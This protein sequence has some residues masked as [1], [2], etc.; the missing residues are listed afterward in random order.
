MVFWGGKLH[1]E[2]LTYPNIMISSSPLSNYYVEESSSSKVGSLDP[3]LL[4]SQILLSGTTISFI[5]KSLYL[6]NNGIN[7]NFFFIKK[8]R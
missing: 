5:A 7:H 2:A 1:T 6:R 8:E 4:L 3:I